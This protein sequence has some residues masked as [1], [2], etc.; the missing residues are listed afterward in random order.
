MRAFLKESLLPFLKEHFL[1]AIILAAITGAAVGWLQGLV[2]GILPS[3]EPPRCWIEEHWHAA[4]GSLPAANSGQFTVLVTRLAGDPDGSETKHL[5]GAFLGERGF[6]RLTTCHVIEIKGEDQ[7]VAEQG[8]EAEADQL[9]AARGADL[10]LWGE[11]ADRG[12]LRVWLTGPT[13]RADLKARPWVADKGVLEPAFQEHF[14]LALQAVVLAALAPSIERREGKPTADLLRPLLPRLRN[15]VANPPVGLTADAK[16]SLLFA[17]AWGFES[18]GEQAGDKA[19]LSEAVKAYYAALEELTRERAPLQWAMTQTNLGNALIAL[20]ELEGGT[21]RLE[22]AVKAYYAVLEIFKREQ[23]P[24][25][26]AMAQSNLGV[27]LEALGERESGTARLEDAVKAYNAALEERKRELVPLDWAA[28]EN[29]LGNAL[30]RLGERE[31]GTARLED[32]VKAY[33]AAL[34]ERKRELVPLDW[35]ATK[36]NLGFAL[37]MLGQKLGQRENGTTL[38]KEAVAALRAALEERKRE[39][40]PLD[41]AT[42]ENNLGEALLALAQRENGTTLLAEAVVALRAA[43]E[44]RKRERVPLDW[45]MTQSN[46]GFALLMVGQREN[47][48]AL[49]EKAVAAFRAALEERKRELVPLDWALSFGGQ[50]IALMLIADRTNDGTVAEVA[51]RQIQTAYETTRSG[52]QETWAAYFQAQ[53][54]AAHAIRDRL[55]SP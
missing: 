14:A 16:G 46:L 35:A 32:A 51:V 39:L 17:A 24:L 55:K 36:N 43:L 25:L 11:V 50:G 49:L 48:T 47:G 10:V 44:E 42:T 33:N 12:A 2:S 9:R 22:E 29:N 13:A 34:E 19:S 18:Y 15:L 23:A 3:T 30:A 6:R 5:L 7:N 54:P 8:A 27:A 1:I 37:L 38:L 52:G 20:G 31:S 26:W 4:F 41:W 53:L 28:T 21:A 40:V 45:A